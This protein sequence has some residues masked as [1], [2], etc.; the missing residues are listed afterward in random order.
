MDY[1]IEQYETR[2]E[3]IQE[4]II[5]QSMKYIPK[6]LYSLEV[7][8]L[9]QGDILSVTS[10]YEVTNE[11]FFTTMIASNISLSSQ[12]QYTS[13]TILDESR[14]YNVTKIMHHGIV[15][16]ARQIMLTQDYP[17]LN[18]I[19]TVL[20]AASWDANKNLTDRLHVEKGYGHLDVIVY[21]NPDPEHNYS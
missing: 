18:Y 5:T 3:Q 6:I 20:W 21:K 2:N 14:G 17:G 19:N 12:G 13:G 15:T 7:Y 10:A 11:N 4:L 8:D 1:S 16:H 9:H